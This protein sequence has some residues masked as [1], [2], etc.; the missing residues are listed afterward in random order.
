[1]KYMV[2]GP[3]RIYKFLYSNTNEKKPKISDN[4]EPFELLSDQE[5]ELE[6]KS[7]AKSIVQT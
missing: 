3:R 6:V 7:F 4:P 2:R 5:I 1:M